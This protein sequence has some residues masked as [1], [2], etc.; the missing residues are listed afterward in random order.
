VAPN[1]L[2]EL[3]SEGGRNL[4]MAEID[5]I[6]DPIV[7]RFVAT[8]APPN[9][10][11]FKDDQYAWLTERGGKMANTNPDGS[12]LSFASTE[13]LTG[14]PTGD[15]RQLFSYDAEA[16]TLECASCPADGS[17]PLDEVNR[18]P[19]AGGGETYGWHFQRDEG[20]LR[21]VSSRGTVFFDT[22][23][24]LVDADQNT[25]DDVYEFRGGEVRL[26]SGGA[27][28]NPSKIDNASVD[29]ST[30]VF[31]TAEPLAPQ[32][33]EP[34]IPKIYVAREGG[35]FPDPPELPSCD[36]NAGACEG[37]GTSAPDLPGAG[38]AEFT[39]PGNIDESAQDRCKK[40]AR[41]A[42]KL[43]AR[44]AKLRRGARSASDPERADAM[45]RQ[46]R[47]VA[48]KADKQAAA[49]KRCR[50]NAGREANTKGRA[51]R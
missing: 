8:F 43:A 45:R 17:L 44:A 11:F 51:G 10:D 14:Q 13:N 25:T 46:A 28:G 35:G 3:P 31:T 26:I 4:Y 36:I 9:P 7:L 2:G 19:T 38:S 6:D 48:K 30:V 39:G 18:Y 42:K 49:T 23:T 34:G 29:G 20:E 12:V 32:D 47:R 15:L 50:R 27:G 1:P 22:V 37:A 16:D 40:L 5:G 41:A 21:W 33:E 24:P